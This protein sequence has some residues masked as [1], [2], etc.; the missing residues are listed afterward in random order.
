MPV[1]ATIKTVF[2]VSTQLPGMANCRD[3]QQI[4]TAP[5]KCKGLWP[6]EVERPRDQ[7]AKSPVLRTGLDEK[8]RAKRDAGGTPQ[9]R[10][11]A[12]TDPNRGITA[13]GMLTCPGP[14]QSR[15]RTA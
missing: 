10:H 11:Q 6:D 3:V 13:P 12:I 5:R 8:G 15:L 4:G 7:T 14:W 1:R 9:Q 2:A